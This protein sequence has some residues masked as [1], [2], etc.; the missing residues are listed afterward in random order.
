MAK[1]SGDSKVASAL[2]RA[3]LA[4]PYA[5]VREAAAQALVAVA[6]NSALPTLR[7]L[8]DRDPEPRLRALA[9]RLT[10]ELDPAP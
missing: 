5:L 1:G 6:G 7:Q 8:K 4:D 2:G 3:A 10:R 9:E